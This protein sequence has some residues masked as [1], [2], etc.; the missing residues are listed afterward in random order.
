M[1]EEWP[2]IQ[3]ALI[4]VFSPVAIGV[5][6]LICALGFVSGV[7]SVWMDITNPKRD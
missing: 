3:E 4:L 5:I 2:R 1:I 7:M 6:T